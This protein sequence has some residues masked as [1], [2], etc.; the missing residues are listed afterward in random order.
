[1]PS[2]R[3]RRLV[4]LE[5]IHWDGDS[6]VARGSAASPRLAEPA[7]NIGF[8]FQLATV[9]RSVLGARPRGELSPA[10]ASHA[11]HARRH[12]SPHA[13]E[14][15]ARQAAGRYRRRAD[16][17][18]RVAPR[19]GGRGRP[20]GGRD[21][22]RGDLGGRAQGRRRSRDD[23]RRPRLR[24]RSRVRGRQPR[25]SGRRL[26]DHPQSAGRSADA[27][28]AH[29]RAIASRPCWT[30]GRDIATIAAEITEPEDRTNPN[31][32]QGGRHAD[33]MCPDG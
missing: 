24:L 12:T 10:Q 17:R 5:S 19:H 22:H 9:V 20:R 2:A 30:R 4:D 29:C 1:M 7:A 21:R 3:R 32:G 14:P 27:G 28:A 11:A 26:R 13:V 33:R 18:A 23:P 16:D 6:P 15:A 8:R 31:V 25:R